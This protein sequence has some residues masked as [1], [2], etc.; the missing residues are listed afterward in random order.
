MSNNR[1]EKT[2]LKQLKNQLKHS[3]PAVTQYGQIVT[4]TEVGFWQVWLSYQEDPRVSTALHEVEIWVRASK[5]GSAGM[6]ACRVFEK[7][8]RPDPHGPPYPTVEGMGLVTCVDEKDY[9]SK[10]LEVNVRKRIKNEP[11]TIFY[12]GHAKLPFYFSTFEGRVPKQPAT[13]PHIVH[14]NQVAL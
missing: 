6:L 12:A 7:M 9:K 10:W 13:W 11:I 1:H 5:P 14:P 2:T 4:G 8:H 3:D